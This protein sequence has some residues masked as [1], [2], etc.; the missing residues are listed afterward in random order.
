MLNEDFD[1]ILESLRVKLIGGTSYEIIKPIKIQNYYDVQNTII[2]LN[3]GFLNHNKENH[4]L[5]SGDILFIPGGKKINITLGVNNHTIIENEV[6]QKEKQSFLKKTDTNSKIVSSGAL[7]KTNIFFLIFDARAYN[8]INFFSSLNIPPFSINKNVKPV[9]S[10]LEK[11]QDEQSGNLTGKEKLVELLTQQLGIELFRHILYEKLDLEQL[12]EN[13][14]YFKDA[15]LMDIF[16]YIQENL[17]NDLSNKILANVAGVAPEYMSQFFKTLTG[18]SPQE[19]VEYQRMEKSI[20]LLKTTE[21][22]V[23]EISGSLGFNNTSYFCKRFKMMFGVTPKKMRKE[24]AYS[25][26]NALNKGLGY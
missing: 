9:Q 23:H 17:N 20:E 15:R 24:N 18:I 21:L 13:N 2:L 12:S 3:F 25:S 8:T 19:Y 11:I 6:F 26:S 16:N 22:S 7:K 1:K 14:N 4:G 5:N 10:V